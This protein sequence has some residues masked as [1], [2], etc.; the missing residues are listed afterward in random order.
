MK[1]SL[2]LFGDHAA[3]LALTNPA[4]RSDELVPILNVVGGRMLKSEKRLFETSGKS[5]GHAWE[6]LDS[7]TITRKRKGFDGGT[8]I[9][10]PLIRS[11]HEMRS[12][13]E[14]GAPDNIYR[15]TR[16]YVIIGSQAPGVGPQT[17]GTKHMVARPPIQFTDKQARDWTGLIDDFIF[18]GKLPRA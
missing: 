10:K 14:R 9:R 11:G 13:S 15:V 3:E 18:K 4:D 5:G 2:R 17:T 12:L 6:P 16:L 7:E 1:T 8:R